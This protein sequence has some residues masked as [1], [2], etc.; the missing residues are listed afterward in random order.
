MS[1]TKPTRIR[2]VQRASRLLMYVVCCPRGATVTAAA[3]ACDLAVPTAHH[4]LETLVAEGLL[5]R[6]SERRF[7]PGPKA[8]VIADRVGSPGP[9]PDFLLEPLRWLARTTGETSYLAAWRGEEMRML[10]WVEGKSA[11]PIV[12]I[13]R[14]AYPM[15]HARATG[16]ALLAFAS[17]RHRDEY[18]DDHPL[19]Q[20]TA[21]TIVRREV[22]VEELTEARS[23][24]WAEDHEEFAPGISCLSVPVL[25]DGAL[26]AALTVSAP[27]GRFE[28]GRDELLAATMHAAGIAV[29][30]GR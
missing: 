1:G 24:G 15:G 7:V 12:G 25:L 2:S 3:S 30:L 6:D 4:L 16:K 27:T 22:L 21:K 18:L 17:P 29:S 19:P 11:P 9:T 28:A 14:G 20:A 10:N 5:A 26:L 13:R 23:R 8:M